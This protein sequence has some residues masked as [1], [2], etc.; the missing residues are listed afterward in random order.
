MKHDNY[1]TVAVNPDFIIKPTDGFG[2]R[3]LLRQTLVQLR[4]DAILL[5]TDPRFFIWVWEMADEI[6]QI[7]PI[8]Y[9]H[10]WDN[11]P[12]PDFNR[13]LYES[14]DL[15]NCINWPTYQMVK[16]RFPERTNYIPHSVPKDLYKPLPDDQVRSFKKK[17]EECPPQD[18]QRHHKFLEDI[19]R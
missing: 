15:I 3:N 1:E 14:T 5:F 9:W 4:P 13:V 7:C 6:R 19:F 18:A 12:W 11:D 2:D 8:T 10:L 16:E 17:F